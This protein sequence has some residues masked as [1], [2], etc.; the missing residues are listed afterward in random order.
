MTLSNNTIRKDAQKVLRQSIDNSHNSNR[1]T[2]KI[3][4]VSDTI[5]T[6]DLM[7][8]LAIC[9]VCIF[10]YSN[11][12]N[13]SFVFDDRVNIH[14]NPQIRLTKLTLDGIIGAGFESYASH[15][16]VANVSFAL[17]Y[18]FHR[19]DVIGYHLVNILIH[20]ITGIILFYQGDTRI[21]ERPGYKDRA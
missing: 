20:I 13:S 9:L 10:I 15:R 16:P 1:P 5:F 6:Y 17:N 3:G 21:I 18:Y 2:H 11:I 19:Y 4:K 7:V 12:L 14:H 8:I